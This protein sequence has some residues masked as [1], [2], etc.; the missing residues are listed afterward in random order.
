MAKQRTVNVRD[1]WDVTIQ[2]L[3]GKFI[4]VFES[5]SY[6]VKLHLTRPWVAYIAKLLWEFIKCEERAI[7][8]ARD[9]LEGE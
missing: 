3:T 4:L 8:S 1:A 7:K 9:D 6:V 2:N 5:E